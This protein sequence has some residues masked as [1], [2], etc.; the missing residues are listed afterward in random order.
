MNER[1]AVERRVAALIGAYA[2]RAP[3]DVDPMAMTRV[4]AVAAPRPAAVRAGFMLAGRGLAFTF[5]ILALLIAIAAGAL[6]TSGQQFRRDPVEILTDRA[7]VEP[8]VGLPSEGIAPSTPETGQLVLSFGGRVRS[9]GLDFHRVW[10]FADGRLIWKRN[11]DGVT[12]TARRAFGARE[13]TTA[14]IEQRLTPEGVE[15]MRSRVLAA[16]LHDIEPADAIT[17][18][19]AWNRPG[20]LWGGLVVHDGDRLVDAEWSDGELPG[21]LADPGSWIPASAWVDRRI[22]AYVPSRYAVCFGHVR[23]E[24]LTEEISPTGIW[25]LL[26]EQTR[27][28]IRSRTID[29]IREWHEQDARCLYQVSTDDARTITT[30]LD[31]V[32]LSDGIPVPDPSGLGEALV[33]EGVV[34]ILVVLPNGDVVCECG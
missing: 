9:I 14:V 17:D 7:F 11:L 26:P 24:R 19:T 27:S 30:A 3:I 15:L 8:F 22:G 28:L 21:L 34:Q 6:F 20:V 4:A 33:G 18:G 10:I 25:D 12:D 16:G 1:N 29:P 2:D 5:F 32:G 31:D 23:P 13:P